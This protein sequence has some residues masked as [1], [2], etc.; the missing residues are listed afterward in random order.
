MA[1]LIGARNWS[2]KYLLHPLTYSIRDSVDIFDE[3]SIF[4]RH[5][6]EDNK[7]GSPPNMSSY[8]FRKFC[9]VPFMPLALGLIALAIYFHVWLPLLLSFGAV[10]VISLSVFMIA[11]GVA[12][13]AIAR[14]WHFFAGFLDRIGT[15][16]Y[17]YLR[18]EEIDMIVCDG[19]DRTASVSA[20]PA[21]K[22]T[23]ALRFSQLKSKV[24]RPFSA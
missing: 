24:C 7:R 15:S 8:I 16:D 1:T 3:G 5:L 12:G 10:L 9:L 4:I 23:I 14:M 22:R 20:L 2:L 19:S 13:Q 18:Q 17:W 11:E 21:K 6:P